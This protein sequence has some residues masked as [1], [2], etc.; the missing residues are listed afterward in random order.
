MKKN[1]FFRI[2]TI[3]TTCA[4]VSAHLVGSE[5]RVFNGDIDI[6]F[7]VP[8]RVAQRTDYKKIYSKVDKNSLK[9]YSIFPNQ[10]VAISQDL[11]RSAVSYDRVL[12][13]SNS[14]TSIILSI[15]SGAMRYPAV[16]ALYLGSNQQGTKYIAGSRKSSASPAVFK[17]EKDLV[18]ARSLSGLA[19]SLPSQ[20]SYPPNPMSDNVV[21][22]G[23]LLDATTRNALVTSFQTIARQWKR[24][25]KTKGIKST[26]P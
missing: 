20:D 8:V 1:G 16:N 5:L 26:Y 17:L 11:E 9:I 21:L 25:M 18:S 3:I 10:S 19:D 23:D 6:I 7:V 15:Q 4:L 12:W 2:S 24:D 14:L 22:Y 13:V